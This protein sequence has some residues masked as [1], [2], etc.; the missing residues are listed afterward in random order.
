[1]LSPSGQPS[2]GASM[3]I[4]LARHFSGAN[5]RLKISVFLSWRTRHTSKLSGNGLFVMM[6]FMGRPFVV[7]PF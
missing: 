5:S 2:T 3:I 4:S 1:M 7:R 6:E